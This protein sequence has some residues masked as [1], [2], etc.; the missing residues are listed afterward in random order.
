ME[1]LNTAFI[2]CSRS[3]STRLPNKPFRKING[4]PLIEH[5]LNRLVKTKIPIILAV[6]TE[7]HEKY[8][9]LDSMPGVY[10]FLGDK[11]DPQ[12]RMLDAADCFNVDN[13]IRVTHDKIFIHPQIVFDA[14]NS[15]MRGK[16]DYLYSSHFSAGT[17]FEILSR[18]VLR[19]A[20]ESYSNVEFIS[21]SVKSV[22]KNQCLFAVPASLQT[23]TR[24]L[25][26][27]PEDITLLE[28]VLSSLGNDCT[29]PEV[30]SFCDN[31]S[32][33]KYINRLPDI[34]VYTCAHNAEKT[35]AKTMQSVESQLNF[36]YMEYIV[37]DDFS[38]DNTP[39]LISR[40]A[41]GKDNI[42]WQ[43]NYEN[44]GLA[45]SSNIA[46]KE[47]RGRYIMRV[48][49]DDYLADAFACPKLLTHMQS[50]QQIDILYPNFYDG[51][52]DVIA[53]NRGFHHPAGALF[54]TKALNHIKFT[55][56][57]RHHDGLDLYQRAKSQLKIGYFNEPT[58]FYNH[59]P[60]SMSRSDQEKRRQIKEAILCQNRL[61]LI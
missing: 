31:H 10:L 61:E 59:T 26:D 42:K 8:K 18:G 57:L 53:N 19:T 43:R 40:F 37:I 34:S 12:K 22:T 51:C 32:W 46:L 13:I 28:T 38:T 9:Y 58:F 54:S 55:D 52:I 30:I 5:L 29:L 35:I 14:L 27:Y 16:F 45:S 21:Y 41:T 3:D 48:D 39:Y 20:C 36:K 60:G 50:N 1:Q 24:L 44:I 15:F 23:T 6:P 4:L 7:D 56:N 33:I 25:V 2:V 11:N 17:A 49:A 47:A